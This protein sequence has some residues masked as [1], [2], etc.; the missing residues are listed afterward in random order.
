MGLGS[1]STQL[2]HG[3]HCPTVVVKDGGDA[4]VCEGPAVHGTKASQSQ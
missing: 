2:V 1:V 4:A 3:L